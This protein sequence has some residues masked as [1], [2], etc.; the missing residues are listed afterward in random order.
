MK[1]KAG[2]V[3]QKILESET[4]PELT[5]KNYDFNFNIPLPDISFLLDNNI[6]LLLDEFPYIKLSN[7]ERNSISSIKYYYEFYEKL[8]VI[9]EDAIAELQS[10]MSLY[11]MGTDEDPDTRQEHEARLYILLLWQEKCIVLVLEII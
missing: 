1:E 7:N 5:V 11:D 6:I 2:I 10:I 9:M 4:L 8:H 3:C